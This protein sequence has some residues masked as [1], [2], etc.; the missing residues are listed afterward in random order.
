MEP[1]N[2]SFL[3]KTHLLLQCYVFWTTIFGLEVTKRQTNKKI[4]KKSAWQSDQDQLAAWVMMVIGF[5]DLN[6]GLWHEA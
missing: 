6:G 5:P 2:I 1:L 4:L 3:K